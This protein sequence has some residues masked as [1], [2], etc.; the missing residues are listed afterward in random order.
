MKRS[1][2][3]LRLAI[4][5][6]L[7]WPAVAGEALATLHRDGVTVTIHLE[8]V[9]GPEAE[10]VATF[11][12]D[13]AEPPLHIYSKDLVG[14]VGFPTRLTL[15]PGSPVQ[16]A[17]PLRADKETHLLDGLPVYPA[18]PV[19]V[20]RPVTLPWSRDG[21]P[22]EVTLLLSWMACSTANCLMP[23][24]DAPVN[25]R[26]PSLKR[27]DAPIAQ[28]V[29]TEA[30]AEA[31]R[32]ALIEERAATRQS[33]QEAVASALIR[34]RSDHSSVIRWRHVTTVAEAEALIAE[35]RA[36]K[37]AAVLDFTGPSCVNCQRMAKTVLRQPEVAAAWNRGLPIEISTDPPH[38]ELAAWQQQRFKSQARPLY[39]RLATDGTETRWSEVFAPDD[40]AA[41]ARFLTFLAGGS[42]SDAGIGQGF[43]QFII[44]AMLGGLFTLIMPCTYPMIPFT[45]NFFAKQAAAGQRIMPLAAFYSLGIIACFVGLGVLVTG[46]FGASLATLAGHPLTNLLIAG[47]FLFFGLSLLGAFFLHLP[48]LENALGG[49]RGGYLGALLMGLTFAVTAFTC[50]APFAGTVLAQAVTTGAWSRPVLGM[51]VYAGTIAVPFFLLALSPGVL[52]RLPRAGAWMNEFK[53]VGG[54]VEVAAAF[55]FL[56]ICDVAWNWGLIG[57]ASTVAWWAAS[58]LFIGIYVL[59]LVRLPGDAKIAEA[60]PWRILTALAFLALGLWLA[61]GLAGLDLGVIESFFPSVDA[62]GR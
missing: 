61:A 59:G 48:G 40:R 25:V 57:R 28:P 3:L 41:Q 29:N 53:A 36:R 11:T 26:L 7:L 4:L 43:W 21:A 15:K 16:V 18:G 24:E 46:V 30:L 1:L 44:L 22:V 8:M 19:T 12:P 62:S 55:K 60:G 9:E 58:A 5:S 17:G 45:V 27:A 50:T 20:Y 54:V 37:I 34:E 13:Q 2:L 38:Q 49:G 31:V 6:A 51:A 32:A 23:V 33:V 47:L 14:E 42:G 52:Q 39:V 35:A 56:V 10:L